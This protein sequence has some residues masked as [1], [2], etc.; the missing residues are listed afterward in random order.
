MITYKFFF[1]FA[2]GLFSGQS[3]TV[4]LF[5]LNHSFI[6]FTVW[7]GAWSCWNIVIVLKFVLNIWDK[8]MISDLLIA[9]STDL[10]KK[11]ILLTL[12]TDI[13][14]QTITGWKNFTLFF[15]TFD[16]VSLVQNYL[17]MGTWPLKEIQNFDL[18]LKMTRFH[19]SV[20]QLWRFLVHLHFCLKVGSGFEIGILLPYPSWWHL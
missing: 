4:I 19:W 12:V 5:F 7:G 16:I 9:A 18:S 3:S 14:F 20:D 2:S 10:F 11:Q 17:D 15:H 6:D 1:R 13:H 8:E